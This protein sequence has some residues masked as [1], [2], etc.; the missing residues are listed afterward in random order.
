V[1]NYKSDGSVEYS[2]THKNN[3]GTTETKTTTVTAEEIAT[4]LATDAA[5]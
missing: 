5:N 1:K 3:D 4:K 2:Y